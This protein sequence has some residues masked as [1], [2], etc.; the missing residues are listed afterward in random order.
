MKLLFEGWRKFINENQVP[1]TRVFVII[2]P[3]D[4]HGIGFFAGYNNVT[5]TNNT[6]VGFEAGKGGTG[7]NSSNVGVGK[8]KLVLSN[9]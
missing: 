8:S 2:R 6:Y 1:N 9:E 3:S 5:G 4:I 7:N